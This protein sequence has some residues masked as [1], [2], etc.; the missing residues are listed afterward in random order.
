VF[1][2]MFGCDPGLGGAVLL[3]GGLLIVALI[4]FHDYW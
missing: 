3:M 4:L 1:V 2:V